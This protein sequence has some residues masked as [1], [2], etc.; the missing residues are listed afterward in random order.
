ME[1]KDILA[2]VDSSEYSTTV[3]HLSVY[4]AKKMKAKV[5]G[6]H[7]VDL[8][9]LEGPFM[10]DI[11]GALGFE[12]FSNFSA[13]IREALEEKGKNVLLSFEEI[14]NGLGVPFEKYMEVGVVSRTILDYEDK[15]DLIVIGRKGVNEQYD[16]GILGTNIESILRK[17]KKP[18]LIAPRHFY[19]F[20]NV[21]ACVDSR[22]PSKKVY[23]FAK[24]FSEQFEVPMSA[25][26]VNNRK[27]EENLS[28]YGDIKV[29]ESKTVTDGL[30]EY[31]KGIEKPLVCIGA[32]AKPKLIEIVLG[33]T[34]EN[35]LKR[36]LE[37]HF[38]VV[39]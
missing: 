28:Y 29:I 30:E 16:R 10:Y 37:V 12:P 23:D 35:L 5:C 21:V 8:L 19:T 6:L 9:Q 27:R 4:I 11:S 20:S 7:V 13:K 33:S 32:Y 26:Y 1:I 2:C 14:A 17:A 18:L 22:D 34:T 39:R 25:I 3:M 31:I 24:Y 15:C 38:L 36:D